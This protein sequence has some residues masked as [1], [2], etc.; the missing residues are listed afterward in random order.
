MSPTCP[1]K[2][3][4]KMKVIMDHCWS[5]TRDSGIRVDTLSAVGIQILWPLERSTLTEYSHK[6]SFREMTSLD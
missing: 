6:M 3:S 4:M 1:D 2:S 5:D